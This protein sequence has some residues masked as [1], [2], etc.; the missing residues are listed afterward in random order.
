[1]KSKFVVPTILLSATL[2][3]SV[4]GFVAEI[5]DACEYIN[6]SDFNGIYKSVVEEVFFMFSAGDTLSIEATRPIVVSFGLVDSPPTSLGPLSTSIELYV[7]DILVDADEYPG[8]LSYQ[9]S[10]DGRFEV[11]WLADAGY[12]NWTTVCSPQTNAPSIS[13]PIPTPIPTLTWQGLVVLVGLMAGLA[14]YRR[15]KIFT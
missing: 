7:D 15:N 2:T 12:V 10:T 1:M 14:Y 9:F 11:R 13:A 3:S 5:P 6:N 4:S 8:A